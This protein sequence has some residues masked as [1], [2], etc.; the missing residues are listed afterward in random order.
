MKKRYETPV[1]EI[2]KFEIAENINTEYGVLSG[3]INNNT[4]G[5]GTNNELP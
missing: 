3:D 2:E 5:D 1:V 4:I